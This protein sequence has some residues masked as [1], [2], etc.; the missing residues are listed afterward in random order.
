MA[1]PG[2]PQ[3]GEYNAYYQKY[4]DLVSD[5]DIRMILRVQLADTLALLRPVSESKAA[6]RYGP[7]KW[8]IKQVVGHLIDAE[9]VFLY[10]ATCIARGDRTPLPSFD[11]NKYVD[12][13]NF[14]QRTFQ[15]LLAELE[16]ARAST[17]A[18]FQ[19]ISDDAWRSLGVA[20]TFDISVRAIAYIIAGH[21]LHHRAILADRYLGAAV[22]V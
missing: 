8:S 6:F 11:E 4:I 16:A 17:A 15:G 2:R 1:E 12:G 18:F 9:R 19:N 14:D 7:D 13:A 5:D 21:E 3:A 10:R 22:A 20:S